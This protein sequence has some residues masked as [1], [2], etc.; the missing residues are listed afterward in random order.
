MGAHIQNTPRRFPYFHAFLHRE[1]AFI[2]ISTNY[3]LRRFLPSSFHRFLV[4]R[5][6]PYRRVR[7]FRKSGILFSRIFNALLHLNGPPMINKNLPNTIPERFLTR[8]IARIY[9]LFSISK[10]NH[11]KVQIGLHEPVIRIFF[12]HAYMKFGQQ[13]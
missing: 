10:G 13:Y 7:N 6:L 2:S 3:R 9:F 11:R 8:I 4:E 1:N 12:V 5:G